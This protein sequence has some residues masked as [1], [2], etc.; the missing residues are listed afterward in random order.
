[1][2]TLKRRLASRRW[3]REHRRQRARHRHAAQGNVEARRRRRRLVRGLLALSTLV[4]LAA[5]AGGLVVAKDARDVA[6]RLQLVN[7]R[8]EDAR[9]AI[10]AGDPDT[11]TTQ[12][13]QARAGLTQVLARTRRPL[14]QLGEA[15]PIAGRSLRLLGQ[16]S[17]S[18]DA[19]TALA[20][21]LTNSAEDLL[22][23]GGQLVITTT[24]DRIDLEPVRDVRDALST[25]RIEQ[26]QRSL[27]TLRNA[28]TGLVPGR[29]LEAR[30]DVLDLGARA[31][32][33]IA[34]ARDITT[35][36]PGFLGDDTPREYFL[37]MQ[38]P[39]E[40][41]GT[42]G[43]IGFYATVR[44]F[45]G[46]FTLSEPTS[47][48]A[49]NTDEQDIDALAP[50]PVSRAFD[51]RYGHLNPNGF[52]ANTNV[53]ADLATVAPVILDLFQRTTGRDLDGVILIDP[54]GLRDILEPIGPVT[55]P[56]GVEMGTLPNPVPPEALPAT[57]MND[58][59][60]VLGGSTEARR[61]Y[62]RELSTAAFE[63][64]FEGGWDAIPVTEQVVGTAMQG[65][66]QLFSEDADEQALIE[67]LGIAGRLR[68][69]D[70]HDWVAVVGN[71][72][73]GNKGDWFADHAIAGTISLSEPSDDGSATR[74]GSLTVTVDNA[75][76][77]AGQDDYVNSSS[78]PGRA[79]VD[80]PTGPRGLNR[81]WFTVWTDDETIVTGA[82]SDPARSSWE[83]DDRRGADWVVEVPS[84][85][86]SGFEANLAGPVTIT[87]TA[88]G[89]LYDLHVHRQPKTSADRVDLVVEAPPGWRIVG[90]ELAGGG[91]AATAEP[92]VTPPTVDVDG[93][94]ATIAGDM[95]RSLDIRV[96]MAP[97]GS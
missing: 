52:L 30:T 94:R 95:T 17:E 33:E 83:L 15:V 4:L 55:V 87:P 67:S 54:Y 71:N 49:L 58:A 97:D 82:S 41:R 69:T 70:A 29:L 50:V 32:T 21:D 16:I 28:P 24:G 8:L 92:G 19:A 89:F 42:G 63:L 74:L 85:G 6:D 62:L 88:N 9:A 44:I 12:L 59:Y 7:A 45:E 81:T 51:E 2:S 27:Q 90:V 18:A 75:L 20:R 14:W 86:T 3:R 39:A 48:S 40:L 36:L 37:A 26:L 43:L 10:A 34:V 72:A 73:A 22:T 60:N 47:Y 46:Q 76:P 79:F 77:T 84:M 78:T 68:P 65:H 23:A 80:G 5:V 25:S 91:D 93:A 13:T 61:T 66:L 35:L 38:N 53:D 96:A 11:A 64:F 1:M 57:V 31:L 56:E